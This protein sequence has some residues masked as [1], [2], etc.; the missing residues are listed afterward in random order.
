MP[1][2]YTHQSDF[3]SETWWNRTDPIGS[4]RRRRNLK[5]GTGRTIDPTWGPVDAADATSRTAMILA[6]S[7]GIAEIQLGP[8]QVN[9]GEASPTNNNAPNLYFYFKVRWTKN[10]DA[11]GTG[12]TFAGAAR[13]GW[14]FTVYGAGS[15]FRL[16]TLCATCES[17]NDPKF[18]VTRYNTSNGITADERTSIDFDDDTDY[19]CVLHWSASTGSSDGKAQLWVK[20][21]GE[22]TLAYSDTAHDDTRNISFETFY[23]Y[24]QGVFLGGGNVFHTKWTEFATCDEATLQGEYGGDF[25]RMFRRE[26]LLGVNFGDVSMTEAVVAHGSEPGVYRDDWRGATDLEMRVQYNAGETFDAGSAADSA[27]SDL[28]E[29]FDYWGN[30]KLTGLTPG[31]VYSYRVQV[32]RSSSAADIYSGPAR[33]TKTLPSSGRLRYA[34]VHCLD[35][36][37]FYPQ[38]GWWAMI[39]ADVDWAYCLGDF[40]YSGVGD[41]EHTYQQSTATEIGHADA[42]RDVF[43]NVALL[44]YIHRRPLSLMVDDHDGMPNNWDAS[45]RAGQT[46]ASGLE[47]LS[48]YLATADEADWATG[49][50]ASSGA[51]AGTAASTTTAESENNAT[52]AEHFATMRAFWYQ[53]YYKNAIGMDIQASATAYEMYRYI[54]TGNV[55]FLA[56]DTR[57]FQDEDGT[58]PTS[59]DAASS[60][61]LGA[62]QD[63]WVSA[64]LDPAELSA[65]GI[66]HVE[67]LSPTVV[68]DVHTISDEWNERSPSNRD[69][70]L[71][72]MENAHDV[73]GVTHAIS[74]GDRHVAFA[75][76]RWGTGYTDPA[77]SLDVGKAVG[78]DVRAAVLHEVCI[79]PLGK[80]H[81]GGSYDTRWETADDVLFSSLDGVANDALRYIRV[82]GWKDVDV[83]TGAVGVSVYSSETGAL[84][85]SIAAI[86]SGPTT[87][88]S[89]SDMPDI[90][91]AVTLPPSTSAGDTSQLAALDG[92]RTDRA[93]I[94]TAMG[95]GEVTLTPRAAIQQSPRQRTANAAELELWGD[96]D[97]GDVINWWAY[98]HDA[99]GTLRL[100]A[101]GTA[102]LGAYTTAISAANPD[103]PAKRIAVTRRAADTVTFTAAPALTVAEAEAGAAG[104]SGVA[105]DADGIAR[106]RLAVLPP[107]VD[108]YVHTRPKAAGGPD[109]ALAVVTPRVR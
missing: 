65:A 24:N 45:W 51:T 47:D 31:T 105:N 68:G 17:D 97:D 11:A 20:V 54:D 62:R 38:P 19:E 102:T 22:W 4:N 88:W 84:L 15:N 72:R 59:P 57:S 42:V 14:V 53:A 6:N 25:D 81:I 63:A 86:T 109:D 79:G 66:V 37:Q 83:T 103:E 58:Q 49:F 27:W 67:H 93:A 60:H 104:A 96:G 3:G 94:A 36:A 13:R 10:L 7:G 32:R 82:H 9:F 80:D 29:A 91:D 8:G 69:S 89:F 55:R 52:R 1:H 5:Y 56:L 26:S 12:Q 99:A 41:L 77:A 71:T 61:M 30:V 75:H 107:A 106:V 76:E 74:A 39:A 90:F 16:L 92:T 23:S 95:L 35:Q 44:D 33:T 34:P 100:V 101:S 64:R 46:V 73:A 21:G 18:T 48:A 40:L 85:G 2:C 50:F 108:L 43:E 87:R 70:Y 28:D 98:A 78:V